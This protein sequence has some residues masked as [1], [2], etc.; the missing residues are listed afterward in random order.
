M[1]YLEHAQ[2]VTSRYGRMLPL[3]QFENLT[4]FRSVY[5]LA[6]SDAQEIITARSSKG[7]KRFD[8]YA[9]ELVFDLDDGDKGLKELLAWCSGEGFGYKIYESGSKGL[10][11]TTPHIPK[12]SNTLPSAHKEIAKKIYPGTDV[13]IYRHGS[14]FRLP[15]TIHKKTGKPKKLIEQ[16][17]GAAILDFD[18]PEKQPEAKFD[19]VVDPAEDV[20][21]KLSMVMA[22]YD[23][24]PGK[25]NRHTSLWWMARCL[26]DCGFSF[27]FSLELI[28]KINESW[29]DDAHDMDEVLRAIREVF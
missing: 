19:I 26:A 14:L 22:N 21:F 25:G 9:D 17:E 4:G 16:V 20:Q 5:A 15:G 28:S 6:E 7:F 12:Y 1:F 18:V 23:S 13:S 2:D 24:S 29:Q 10:H 11:F 3:N 27:D 8:V